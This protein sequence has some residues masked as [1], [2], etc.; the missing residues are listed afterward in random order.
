MNDN[1]NKMINQFVKET[2]FYGGASEDQI[3]NAENILGFTFPNEYREYLENYGS[4]GI[5]GVDLQGIEGDLGASVVTATERY[6]K[7]G[8]DE[9]IVVIW[10]LGDFINCMSTNNDPCVYSW[11]RSYPEL[12]KRYESFTDFLADIFQEAI[13]NH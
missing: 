3:R 1:I 10:D 11:Y 6:R 9:N 4:G 7:L 5:C 2:D 8:L 12:V 13:D